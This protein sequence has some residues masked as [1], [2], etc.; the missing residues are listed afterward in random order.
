MKIATGI[1]EILDRS[2]CVGQTLCLPPEK[3]DR[4]VYAAVAKVIETAGGK[5]NKPAQAHLFPGDAAAAIEPVLLTGEVTSKKQ[6]FGAFFT[7]TDLAKQ[8]VELAGFD[9]DYDTLE[10]SAGRGALVAEV[11]K[12]GGMVE[13]FEIQP[14]YVEYLRSQFEIQA[15]V[16]CADFLTVEPEPR[17]ERVVMNPPFAGQADIDHVLHAF[18]F[19]TEGGR[20][21]SITS[22]SVLFRKNRKAAQFRKFVDDHGGSFKALPPDS[23][24]SSGTSV[25]ACILVIET[26]EAALIDVASLVSPRSPAMEDAAC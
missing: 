16:T 17:F 19:L 1:L 23:F 20:L 24:K 6:E 12:V 18:Q 4:A 22:E 3:L 8:V 7:P 10:P 26:S 9:R 21:V 14:G 15:A 13:C 2:T 25:N 11:L 5:W